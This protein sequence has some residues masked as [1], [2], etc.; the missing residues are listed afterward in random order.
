MLTET[1]GGFWSEGEEMKCCCV[2]FLE[3]RANESQRL[4]SLCSLT[5]TCFLFTGRRQKH[6][7]PSHHAFQLAEGE[8]RAAVKITTSLFK[9]LLQSHPSLH[10]S[11]LPP[12]P[13]TASE[14]GEGEGG[15]RLILRRRTRAEE[16]EEEE[17][18]VKREEHSV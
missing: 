10:P 12:P 13:S 1:R 8:K 16:K 15:L 6:R 3:V 17:G 2:S 4:C 9:E 18:E 14:K 7:R 5:L 11:T